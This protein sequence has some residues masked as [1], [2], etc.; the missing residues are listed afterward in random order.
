MS[1]VSEITGKVVDYKVKDSPLNLIANK[2]EMGVIT[3]VV[4]ESESEA[5][6]LYVGDV[7]I[8]SG[9]GFDN[10]A[11]KSAVEELLSNPKIK[12]LLDGLDSNNTDEEE[13]EEPEESNLIDSEI[14]VHDAK[15]SIK[16]GELKAESWVKISDLAFKLNTGE[17]LYGKKPYQF[18]ITDTNKT[19]INIQFN[20]SIT[21]LGAEQNKLYYKV[22]YSEN[23]FIPSF[24]LMN[25]TEFE[26][27]PDGKTHNA[28]LTVNIPLQR[29]PDSLD[30]KYPINFVITNEAKDKFY[31]ENICT[32][33]YL[34]PVFLT[35]TTSNITDIDLGSDDSRCGY[36]EPGKEIKLSLPTINESTYNY[37]WVPSILSTKGFIIV[38]TDSNI[39]VEWKMNKTAISYNDISYDRYISPWKYIGKISWIIK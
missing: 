17:I 27:N 28:S 30:N 23:E 29:N 6:A 9:Y 37:I 8:A 24:N 31:F 18:K 21:R 38:Y 33:E 36:Y 20:Y 16:N 3:A 4:T 11:D 2:D 1:K 34:F 22:D 7:H 13:P 5:N 39:A 15:I 26:I 32:V 35:S 12:E 14:T 19:I 25:T 10:S